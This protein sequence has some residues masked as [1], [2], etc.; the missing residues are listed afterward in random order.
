MQAGHALCFIFET[1]AWVTARVDLLANSIAE[2]NASF[3]SADMFESRDRIKRKIYHHFLTE[4]ALFKLLLKVPLLA[5]IT[6][7]VRCNFALST[8][9]FVAIKASNSEFT[10]MKLC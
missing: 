10:E 8:E 3:I 6:Q 7:M 2:L 9:I 4:S 1:I 5:I